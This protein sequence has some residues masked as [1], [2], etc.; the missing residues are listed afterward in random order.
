MYISNPERMYMKILPV[1][2]SGSLLICIFPIFF[3]FFRCAAWLVEPGPSAVKERSPNHWTAREFPCI[4]PSF[5]I[6][7]VLFYNF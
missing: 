3:F 4:F 2:V 6:D 5:Y 7:C 1:I